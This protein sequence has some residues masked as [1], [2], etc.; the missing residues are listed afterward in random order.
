MAIAGGGGGGREWQ[1]AAASPRVRGPAGQGPLHPVRPG[2]A[3]HSRGIERIA[4]VAVAVALHRAQGGTGRAAGRCGQARA[5]A[6]SGQKMRRAPGGR[7]AGPSGGKGARNG[8]VAPEQSA[9]P[10]APKC[11]PR[12]LLRLAHRAAKLRR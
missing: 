11:P 7:Q 5:H 2:G 1:A 12:G 4:V 10:P 3:G 6:R 8:R 9:G